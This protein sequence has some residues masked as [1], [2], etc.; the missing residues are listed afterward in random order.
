MAKYL[1]LALFT[2]SLLSTLTIHA[3][4]CSR[5]IPGHYIDRFAK[6]S[7]GVI[8]NPSARD[9][10]GSVFD[11]LTGL[12][13]MRCDADLIWDINSQQCIFNYNA[14]QQ[15]VRSPSN[16]QEALLTTQEANS[17]AALNYNDWRLPNIKELASLQDLSCVS[18]GIG[19]Y[20][21]AIDKDVFLHPQASYWSSTPTRLKPGSTLKS[22]DT[23][24]S[25]KAWKFTNKIIDF[26]A[27]TA[28][29][30]EKHY[31]RL[32]RGTSTN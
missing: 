19:G 28:P 31:V 25:P 14:Q 27:D 24:I 10:S 12:T 8:F 4:D 2:I 9:S 6:D 23:T 5:N 26:G 18:N 11:R 21:I 32:V 20:D 7:S 16:W 13:W 15:I 17:N 30:T 22:G 29:I 3:A 1:T